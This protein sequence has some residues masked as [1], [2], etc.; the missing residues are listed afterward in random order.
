MIP[1][2]PLKGLQFRIEPGNGASVKEVCGLVALGPISL[3][4]AQ[5]DLGVTHTL[6]RGHICHTDPR[7]F[8]ISAV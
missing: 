1:T 6:A 7:L 3:C 2:T 4:E 8:S 5:K